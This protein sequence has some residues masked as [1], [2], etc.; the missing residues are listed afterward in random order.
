[1]LLFPVLVRL[2]WDFADFGGFRHLYLTAGGIKPQIY[3]DFLLLHQ[4]ASIFPLP[5][6]SFRLSL[7]MS[8][9]GLLHLFQ[10]YQ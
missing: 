8:L 7:I 5:S 9:V 3:A 6:I 1:M 4:T 2:T 10:E